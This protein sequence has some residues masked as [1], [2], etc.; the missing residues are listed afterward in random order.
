[1][2]DTMSSLPPSC[3]RAIPLS[4]S[5]SHTQTLSL[6]LSGLSLGNEDP[7][8]QGLVNYSAIC[9]RRNNNNNNDNDNNNSDI[10]GIETGAPNIQR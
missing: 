3:E 9:S 2:V 10:D 1:M 7:S 4:L 5:L 6:P 8:T